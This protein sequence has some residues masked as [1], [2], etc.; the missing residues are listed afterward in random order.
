MQKEPLFTK[1]KFN[2]V[3]YAL[4]STACKVP[5]EKLEE[6]FDKLSYEEKKTKYTMI[7]M[8]ESLINATKKK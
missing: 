2:K 7:V 5:P 3:E 8:L 6:E 4:L 1:Y